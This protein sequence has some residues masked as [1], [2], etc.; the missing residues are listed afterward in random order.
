[1]SLRE[2][3]WKSFRKENAHSTKNML[4]FFE[5]HASG[6]E[7]APVWGAAEATFSEE[8]GFFRGQGMLK[9]VKKSNGGGGRKGEQGRG[10]GFAL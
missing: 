4:P 6:R 10:K 1:M 3:E 2:N 7:A 8:M 9:I 5:S